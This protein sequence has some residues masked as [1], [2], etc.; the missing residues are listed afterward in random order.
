MNFQPTGASQSILQ[1]DHT[2][3]ADAAAALNAAQ[4][5]GANVVITDPAHQTNTVTLLAVDVH[6]ISLSDFHIV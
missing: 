2:I 1:F 6:N 5:V 3:F 4:Q